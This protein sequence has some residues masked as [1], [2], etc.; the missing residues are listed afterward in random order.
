MDQRPAYT[1]GT[2]V[3]DL[4]MY[5]RMRRS[6][7]DHGFGEDCEFIIVDNSTGNKGSAYS[8]LNGV[9]N[10]A[11]GRFVILCHQDIELVH[12]G[13]EQL[14]SCLAKLEQIDPAWAVAG[15]AGCDGFHTRYLWMTKQ[16]REHLPEGFPKHTRPPKRVYSLDE[17]FLVIKP[18]ARLSFSRDM[19]GFHMYG[20]DIC[21][22][23][24]VLG[25]TAYVI[26]FSLIHYG[27]GTP[28]P[29]FERCKNAFIA[30]WRRALRHREMQTTVT[31]VML[32]GEN[33]PEWL[34]WLKKKWGRFIARR[35]VRP[36]AA[37]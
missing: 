22:I 9:L 2:L 26:P 33:C 8:A 24:D 32:V 18:E 12:D 13:R 14:D 25:W 30:K 20:P 29:Q 6:M 27:A 34:A 10:E 11:R 21:M 4:G 17:N 7:H 28:G 3:N 37:L 19:D 36:Q 23:A 16:T 1:I 35:R 31:H 15:N 5:E